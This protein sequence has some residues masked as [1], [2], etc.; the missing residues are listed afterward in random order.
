MAASSEK[1]EHSQFNGAAMKKIILLSALVCFFAALGVAAVGWK[2]DNEILQFDLGGGWKDVGHDEKGKGHTITFRREGEDVDRWKEQ[3]TYT[4]GPKSHFLLTPEK[5][6][7]SVKTLMQKEWR[8]NVEFNVIMAD[9]TRVLYEWHT[10]WSAQT[11]EQHD[12]TLVV[13]GKQNWFDLSYVNREKDFSPETR[14]QWITTLSNATIKTA[15]AA[16]PE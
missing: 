7:N 3:V 11:H 15:P 1:S 8:D 13:H 5:E 4:Y 14:Q 10:K 16:T 6:A 12:V 9:E 2:S